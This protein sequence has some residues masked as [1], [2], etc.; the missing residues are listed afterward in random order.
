MHSPSCCQ[1]KPREDTLLAARW[2]NGFNSVRCAPMF[3]LNHQV[4]ALTAE[5][6]LRQIV[7]SATISDDNILNNFG[8]VVI[9][10]ILSI[11]VL[12][13]AMVDAWPLNED[14][15]DPHTGQLLQ[16]VLTSLLSRRVAVLSLMAFVASKAATS[17][18]LRSLPL[19]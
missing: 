6:P 11:P 12:L 10:T 18:C 7:P 3:P 17:T 16:L 2:S 9:G 15:I 19:V 14:W 5:C 8:E 1:N 13:L 4:L